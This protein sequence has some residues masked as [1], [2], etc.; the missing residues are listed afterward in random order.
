MNTKL[1]DEIEVVAR[2]AVW[3]AKENWQLKAIS[4]P[5][6]RQRFSSVSE[7]KEHLIST[8][9]KERCRHDGLEFPLDGPDIIAVRGEVCLK[10][11]CKGLGKGKASTLRNNFDRRVR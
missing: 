2:T 5:T 10:I 11:E 3:L 4:I 7:R 6:G 1:V 8:L 9:K